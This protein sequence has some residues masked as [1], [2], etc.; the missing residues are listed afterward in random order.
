MSPN[1]TAVL[2]ARHSAGN[3]LGMGTEDARSGRRAAL[4]VAGAGL[5]MTAAMIPV[6]LADKYTEPRGLWAVFGPL[7]LWSFI[8]V[9]LYAAQRP[10]SRRFGVLMVLTG[11]AWFVSVVTLL[12]NALITYLGLPLGSIWL[13]LVA[14]SLLAFS[15]GRLDSAADRVVAGI[16]LV[17]LLFIW[18]P[19]LLLDPELRLIFECTECPEN[20]LAIADAH[21]IAEALVWSRVGLLVAGFGAMCVLLGRRWQQASVTQRR[22]LTPVLFSG[23]LLAAVFVFT[24]SLYIAP[25]LDPLALGLE[26]AIY[27]AVAAVPLAFLVGL[28][29]G[30]LYRTDA[31]A[32]LVRRLGRSLDPGQLRDALADALHDSSLAIAFWLP[33]SRRYVTS[34][35]QP[36]E[37]PAPSSAQAATLIEHDGQPVAALIHTA[38]LREDPRLVEDVGAA[39]SLALRNERLEAELRAQIKEVRRSRARLITAED[40]ERRR[41]ERDLHDGAQQRFV[42]LALQLRRARA[43]LED[44][45]APAALLDGALDELSVGL[46]ELRELARGIHPAILGDK[47]LEGALRT[48]VARAPIPVNVLELPDQRLPGPVETAVYFVISEALTNVAKYAHASE[49]NVSVAQM[50][51]VAVVRVS[52][53]GIGGADPGS[54]SGLRGLSDRIAA[55]DGDLRIDSPPGEGTTLRARLPVA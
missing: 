13:A 55:L 5:L 54:G 49:V 27:P 37:L 52:D 36:V 3:N 50:D 4:L 19:T 35:G 53:D 16:L 23:L 20:P 6:G 8:G 31:A 21:S 1:G 39:A 51:G 29:R 34:D 15:T 38:A 46:T 25:G 28:A 11:F 44:D 42:T 14:Y 26:W 32:N 41:L 12:D 18:F 2:V 10:R 24:G 22:S 9:G 43:Q 45:A 7:I 17:A 30:H 33:E 47:G 48:L 40:S